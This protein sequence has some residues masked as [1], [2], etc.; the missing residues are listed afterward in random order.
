MTITVEAIY[1][2]GLLKLSQP[3]PLKEQERVQVTVQSQSPQQR[4][5]GVVPCTDSKLIEW[6]AMDAE[7]EHHAPKDEEVLVNPTIQARLGAVRRSY[8]ILRWTGTTDELEYL[9]LDAENDVFEV[10]TDIEQFLHT[11]HRNADPSSP[12]SEL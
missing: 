5:A 9:A 4:M 10:A 3:L 6:A 1:E 12:A 11:E 7:L 8:G 2:N